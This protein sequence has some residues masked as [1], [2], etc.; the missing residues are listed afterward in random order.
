MFFVA[1]SISNRSAV[2]ISFFPLPY[3]AELPLFLLA[4]VCFILGVAVAGLFMGMRLSKLHGL[5]RREKKRAQALK[6]ELD[7][8]NALPAQTLPATRV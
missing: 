4:L 3:E 2:A 5:F 7:G 6:N 1:F 8:L